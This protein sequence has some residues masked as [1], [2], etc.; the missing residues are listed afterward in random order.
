[1]LKSIL[2]HIFHFPALNWRHEVYNCTTSTPY[3]HQIGIADDNSIWTARI[4]VTTGF[5]PPVN[6]GSSLAAP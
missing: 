4:I 3:S 5:G 2:D 6:G 1:M